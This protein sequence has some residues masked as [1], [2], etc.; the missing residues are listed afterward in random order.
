[1]QNEHT[2]HQRVD[3]HRRPWTLI[4]TRGITMV[5]RQPFRRKKPPYFSDAS[6][7]FCSSKQRIKKKHPP[8]RRSFDFEIMS[9]NQLSSPVI[10]S[11][12]AFESPPAN[13][14]IASRT[15]EVFGRRRRRT[16]L[17]QIVSQ[18]NATTFELVEPVINSDKRWSFIVR[19]QPNAIAHNKAAVPRPIHPLRHSS[20][21]AHCAGRRYC[22]ENRVRCSVKRNVV[23]FC[24]RPQEWR[25]V[26]AT[27]K[28]IVGSRVV[29]AT[30]DAVKCESDREASWFSFVFGF[31]T[32][33]CI[34]T[35]LLFIVSCKSYFV[36]RHCT[37]RTTRPL[38][39]LERG[40]VLERELDTGARSKKRSKVIHEPDGDSTEE[41]GFNSHTEDQS[42][43]AFD[44]TS[45]RRFGF[46]ASSMSKVR[47]PRKRDGG[48]N[49]T[50][51]TTNCIPYKRIYVLI[52]QKNINLEVIKQSS[53][54]IKFLQRFP[55]ANHKSY[56]ARPPCASNGPTAL[57]SPTH[58]VVDWD[59]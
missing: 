15:D 56:N 24:D 17:M 55:K 4:N 57:I 45:S 41:T 48:A 3:D 46:L 5:R 16:S 7:S 10:T 9:V 20:R 11:Y 52:G 25:R 49:K 12:T 53:A 37:H 22:S 31:S 51:R 28:Y 32:P 35:F 2:S 29:L 36:W 42:F 14:C 39:V 54:A 33:H 27:L 8:S 50:R 38:F 44:S 47:G 26:A 19:G 40:T 30:P 21:V 1:M 23:R 18:I 43:G 59:I 58:L 6:T 34:G 13:L